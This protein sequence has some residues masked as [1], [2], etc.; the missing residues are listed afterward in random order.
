MAA[1]NKKVPPCIRGKSGAYTIV[2]EDKVHNVADAD[3]ISK[4]VDNDDVNKYCS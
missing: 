2:V 3:D 1:P 4:D